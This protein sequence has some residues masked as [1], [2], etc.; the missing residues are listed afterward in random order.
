[1]VKRQEILARTWKNFLATQSGGDD[2]SF[3]AAWMKAR[4]SALSEAGMDPVFN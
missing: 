4:A 3:E 1:L 2:A